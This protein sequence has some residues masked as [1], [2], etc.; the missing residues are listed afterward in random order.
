MCETDVSCWNTTWNKASEA[1]AM[2]SNVREKKNLIPVCQFPQ[3]VTISPFIIL[4]LAQPFILNL[5]CI[6]FFNKCGWRC[7]LGLKPWLNLSQLFGFM[8]NLRYALKYF[9]YNT[10]LFRRFLVNLVVPVDI[11]L[12]Y[13]WFQ[14]RTLNKYCAYC[15]LCTW[16][17]WNIL[18]WTGRYKRQT[19]T[20]FSQ[21]IQIIVIKEANNIGIKILNNKNL[22]HLP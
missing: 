9:N 22:T 17:F 18:I 11:R 13:R 12:K 20:C 10:N 5:D 4:S 21:Q 15:S 8:N 16:C 2:K 14:H 6:V 1:T 19:D 3:D 7:S